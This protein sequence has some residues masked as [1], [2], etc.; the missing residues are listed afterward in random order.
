[1]KRHRNTATQ[2]AE[3]FILIEPAR[4][5]VAE[6]VGWMLFRPAWRPATA[7]ALNVVFL[8]VESYRFATQIGGLSV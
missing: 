7:S 8:C 2:A 3:F 1:M 6:R 5:I 4:S